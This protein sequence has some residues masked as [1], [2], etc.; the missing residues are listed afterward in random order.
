MA[1]FYA[2]IKSLWVVW[3]LGI[4]IAIWVWAFWPSNRQRFEAHGRIPLNDD[5][6]APGP[7]D[8]QPRDMTKS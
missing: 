8:S 2:G 5:D 3:L 6:T 4:F 1:E 7:V